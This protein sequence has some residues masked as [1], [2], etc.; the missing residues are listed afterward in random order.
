MKKN[1]ML[2]LGVILAILTPKASAQKSNDKIVIEISKEVDG[3]K[4]TFKGEYNNMEEMRAD[5][6]YQEFS[7]GGKRSSFRVDSGD[8][9][10]VI[11]LDKMEEMEKKILKFFNPD[12]DGF[13]FHFDTDSA[14]SFHFDTE[15]FER[16]KERLKDFGLSVTNNIMDEGQEEKRNF[17]RIEVS[18]VEGE[19]GRRGWVEKNE[20]ALKDLRLYP[21][22]RSE[23]KLNVRFNT[24]NEEELTIKVSNKRGV[25]IFSRYF[26]RFFGRYSESIDLS[27]QEEGVYLLEIIQGKKKLVRKIIIH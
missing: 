10:V 26:V 22:F 1:L 14:T 17:K 16:L 6:N 12:E 19:F 5:P 15:D 23:G 25:D 24:T 11:H 27:D 3:E 9:D 4:K 13:F 7:S 18:K 8:H 2:F 20:L 21:D